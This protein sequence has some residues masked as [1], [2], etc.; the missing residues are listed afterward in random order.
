MKKTFAILFVLFMF[1]AGAK[2]QVTIILE[3]HNVWNDGTGYVMLLDA[4][5]NLDCNTIYGIGAVTEYGNVPASVFANFEY[6]IPTNAEGNLSSSHIVLDGSESITIPAGTYDFCICNPIPGDAMWIIGGEWGVKNDYV[7]EDGKTY[8]FT[9]SHNEIQ[10]FATLTITNSSGGGIATSPDTLNFG[11]TALN[12]PTTLSASISLFGV[13]TA[14]ATTAAPFSISL[15]GYTFSTQIDNIH[16]GDNLIV[17]YSPTTAGNIDNG[18]VIF[19]ADSLTA[20][21]FLTGLGVDCEHIS[22]PLFE[23]C[24]YFSPCWQ[25]FNESAANTNAIGPINKEGYGNIFHFSS[26]MPASNFIQYLISPKLTSEVP[27]IFKF[28]FWDTNLGREQFQVGYSTSNDNPASFTWEAQTTSSASIQNYETA[29]PANTKYVA[30]K[31]LSDDKFYLYLDNFS[32][33]AI[34]TEPTISV[35]QEPLNFGSVGIGTA[36]TLALPLTAFSLDAG[37]TISA[38]APFSVSTDNVNFAAAAT[39]PSTGPVTEGMLFVK[40]QPTTAGSSNDQIVLSSPNA[41][42]PQIAVSGTGVECQVVSQLPWSENFEGA[43]FP[44]LCWEIVSETP[45]KTWSPYAYGSTWASCLGSEDDR[46]EQL[47]TPHFDFSNFSDSLALAFDFISFYAYVENEYVDFKIYASTDGGHTFTSEPLW[48]LSDFGPF[49]DLQST[50]AIVD[51]SA[52]AGQSDVRF[53]FS[54]EGAVCQVLFDNVSV[55]HG[56][57]PV[58]VTEIDGPSVR[59]FP[60]PAQDQLHLQSSAVITRLEVFNIAGQRMEA[61]NLSGNDVQ[62]ST[63][64]W[65]PGIYILK[66]NTTQGDFNR[67]VVIAR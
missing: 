11:G 53:A 18:T 63:A 7:F 61:R 22:L 20:T 2:A 48:T 27:I 54:Y 37:V 25:Y 38:S 30:I 6:T 26:F 49:T 51:V 67:K 21:I 15:D 56:S 35:S 1:V 12:N 4:D 19:T 8:H 65:T 5:H 40:F 9:V 13:T 14:T 41:N 45:A 57:S 32:I 55:Y 28:D 29:L 46:V 33:Q 42:T 44:P 66:I 36:K 17:R 58:S 23:D 47:L 3:A 64:T 52:L 31:Y 39:L 24:D 62:L 43:N 50:H 59:L 10:D 60:T 16:H 34:P